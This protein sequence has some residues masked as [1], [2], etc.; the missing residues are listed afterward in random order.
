MTSKPF[1]DDDEF[2]KSKKLRDEILN[3][4]AELKIGN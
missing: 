2:D 3:A 4:F 1:E